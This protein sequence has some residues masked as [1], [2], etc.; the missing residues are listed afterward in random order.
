MSTCLHLNNVMIKL[1]WRWLPALSA[2]PSFA[3]LLFYCPAPESPSDLL[4]IWVVKFDHLIDNR[5][6]HITPSKVSSDF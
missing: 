1:N 2:V 5:I 3:L 6:T 4:A